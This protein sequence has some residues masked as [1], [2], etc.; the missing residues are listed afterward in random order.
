MI[1]DSTLK[2]THQFNTYTSHTLTAKAP[3]LS[4]IT[5]ERLDPVFFPN[6]QLRNMVRHYV[7]ERR[8]EL[9]VQ[10]QGAAVPEEDEEALW[11]AAGW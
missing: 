1:L 4:P 6:I 7:E 11:G 2:A 8:G 9:Q 3:L 10:G 5:G